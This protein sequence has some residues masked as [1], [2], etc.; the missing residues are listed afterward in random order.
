MNFQ[1]SHRIFLTV[2]GDEAVAQTVM[3]YGKQHRV[4]LAIDTALCCLGGWALFMQRAPMWRLALVWAY[5]PVLL[6]R[7]RRKGIPDGVFFETM[8]DIPIWIDD[9]CA[10]TG[11]IGLEELNWLVHHMRLHIFKLGRLQYQLWQEKGKPAIFIH[12]PRGAPLDAA[13]CDAS[14][15][16]AEAFFAQY[17]PRFPRRYYCHSWLLYSG[18]RQF[19]DADANILRFAERFTVLEEKET[20]SQTFLW[21]FGMRVSDENLLQTRRETGV[22][23]DADTLPQRTQLQK[24]AAAYIAAGGTF[25]DAK[26]RLKHG[27]M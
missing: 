17:F 8:E 4:R 19:M 6:R 11:E 10:R 14:L 20:P 5:L 2:C 15:V 21:L 1:E 23:I 27:K 26:G 18:N 16:A 12:I 22:Y 7:Y 3:T 25:G 24:K 13:A 9:Y